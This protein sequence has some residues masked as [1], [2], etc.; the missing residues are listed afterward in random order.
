[1]SFLW[2]YEEQPR[3]YSEKENEKKKRKKKKIVLVLRKEKKLIF[4][5]ERKKDSS[6]GPGKEKS[7]RLWKEKKVLQDSAWHVL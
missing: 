5:G 3:F 2:S 4:H 6:F 7:I 1:M